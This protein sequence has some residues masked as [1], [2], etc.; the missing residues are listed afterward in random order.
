MNNR[1]I[2]KLTDSKT[3]AERQIEEDMIEDDKETG[4][5]LA[6]LV[7]CLMFVTFCLFFAVNI[8][9]GV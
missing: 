1:D 8:V 4:Y 3:Y 5:T 7:G 2:V 9:L 6:I